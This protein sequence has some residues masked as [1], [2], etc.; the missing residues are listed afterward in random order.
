LYPPFGSFL[1]EWVN[2]DLSR[3]KASKNHLSIKNA[4]YLRSKSLLTRDHFP[5]GDSLKTFMVIVHR[6]SEG[7]MAIPVNAYL[8]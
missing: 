8:L 6:S 1:E 4:L 3:V 7:F 5:Y 2:E